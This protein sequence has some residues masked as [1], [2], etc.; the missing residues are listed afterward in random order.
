M[1]VN[2]ESFKQALNLF[3]MALNAA[4]QLKE[5]L[6]K[7]S[8]TEAIET[9]LQQAEHQFK[10]AAS[11]TASS[12]G[13]ELCRGHWP[14]E[15]MVSRDNRQWKCPT[16]GNELNTGAASVTPDEPPGERA[17]FFHGRRPHL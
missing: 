16:C 17:T 10:L 5:L 7:S 8:K 3:T 4:K 15:I 14:P 6:P 13:Y 1:D 2:F 9:A 12:L 11:Q